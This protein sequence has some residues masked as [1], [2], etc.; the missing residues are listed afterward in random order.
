MSYSVCADNKELKRISP[1]HVDLETPFCHLYFDR[2]KARGKGFADNGRH[3]QYSDTDYDFKTVNM[4]VCLDDNDHITSVDFYKYKTT[5]FNHGKN[6]AKELNVTTADKKEYLAVLRE[7][8]TDSSEQELDN[9]LT[10]IQQSD[11]GK[12]RQ[13]SVKKTS[14]SL[15][16]HNGTR[17][18]LKLATV[19]KAIQLSHVYLEFLRYEDL[20]ALCPKDFSQDICPVLH[21]VLSFV[22]PDQYYCI[23]ELQY[24]MTMRELIATADEK[25]PLLRQAVI[26][27][28][29]EKVRELAPYAKLVPD[30][31]PE[32]CPLF[33]A[34]KDNNLEIVRILLENNAYT[35]EMDRD[36]ARYPLELAYL[37]G[38][39]D[40]VRLLI[41]YHGAVLKTYG[42]FKHNTDN[43]IRLC[44]ANKDYEVLELMTPEAYSFDTRTWL[45]PEMFPDMKKETILAISR[46]KGIR[47]AWGL[48]QICPAYENKDYEL[49]RNM[50]Q[51]G[52][53][54]EVMDYF[55]AQDDIEM[56]EASV[57]CHATITLA[58]ESYNLLFERGGE[59]TEIVAKHIQSFYQKEG[60]FFAAMLNNGNVDRYLQIIEK[61][62]C[63][64]IGLGG[65]I[66]WPEKIK[67]PEKY[68]DL[69][70]LILSKN[71]PCK[72]RRLFL[73]DVVRY[74]GDE[75]L[76]KDYFKLFPLP[77]DTNWRPFR[78]N[79]LL[80]NYIRRPNNPY[81]G[82]EIVRSFFTQDVDDKTIKAFE[83]VRD[84]ITESTSRYS[85]DLVTDE[86][87]LSTPEKCCLYILR[88]VLPYVPLKEIDKLFDQNYSFL[89]IHSAYDFATHDGKCIRS[90]PLV[91][92]LKAAN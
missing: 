46:C 34:V 13:L 45:T 39:R 72:F 67:E 20:F 59:W 27:G 7:V 73:E 3:W 49:C 54:Q 30:T 90:K 71:E 24:S 88:A 51:Q 4:N 31:N 23:E 80:R 83:L 76:A 19:L 25:Y 33:H 38:N 36:G 82:A 85:V 75:Q 28:D 57:Q 81:A 64:F 50:L 78:D 69:V 89:G 41:Q 63:P 9:L 86:E 84:L 74:Y 66:V 14:V 21:E 40:I 5:S 60:N 29:I 15:L 44:A 2:E 10:A 65:Y 26:D 43:L 47:M 37:N 42:V 16:D 52:S 53:T 18:T 17:Q 87:S 12:E 58:S 8:V 91:D 1:I 55:I 35:L 62:G 92:A 77:A 70:K 61:R 48:E 22:D 56:F 68:I 11:F 79:D 32:G 6:N